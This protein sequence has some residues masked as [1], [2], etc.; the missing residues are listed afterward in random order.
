VA[1]KIE[2]WEGSSHPR[3]GHR[4]ERGILG[5]EVGPEKRELTDV[6]RGTQK[7]GKQ[8]DQI[9]HNTRKKKDLRTKTTNA[10]GAPNILQYYIVGTKRKT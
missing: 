9:S 10:G 7:F 4:F 8:P 1:K 5:I 3:S 6:F 2:Y